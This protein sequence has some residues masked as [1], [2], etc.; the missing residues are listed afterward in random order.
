MDRVP[1]YHFNLMSS[2]YLAAMDGW[3]Y[4]EYFPKFDVEAYHASARRGPDALSGPGGCD[5]YAVLDDAE[6]LIG[7]FEYYFSDNGTASI[8]FALRPALTNRGLGRDFLEAGVEF[9][10]RNYDYRNPYVYLS[11]DPGNEPA[12]KLYH[13]AGFE[14]IL[15]HTR[16]EEIHMRRRITFP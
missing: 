6:D 11:V 15:S 1:A 13:R 8:G 12:L 3:T 16:G 7:L 2:K 14:P 4:G 10:V 9:L 5:G